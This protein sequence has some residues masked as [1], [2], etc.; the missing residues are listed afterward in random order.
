MFGARPTET[1]ASEGVYEYIT[2]EWSQIASRASLAFA[3][4]L[5]FLDSLGDQHKLVAGKKTPEDK[6]VQEVHEKKW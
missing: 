1:Q 2:L 3:D 6:A 5:S 4:E